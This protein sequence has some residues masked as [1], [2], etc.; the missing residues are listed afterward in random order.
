MAEI[1]FRE[2]QELCGR[3]LEEGEKLSDKTL[4][5]AQELDCKK[6]IIE[7]LSVESEFLDD[8]FEIILGI[9]ESMTDVTSAAFAYFDKVLY[10]RIY[11]GERYVFP[12]PFML[13]EDA[14]A[15]AACLN[16]ASYARRELIPF[17]ITDVPREELEFLCSV[18]PHIDAFTYEDDDDSFYVKVNNE[19][20]MLDEIPTIEI[21]GITLD[22]IRDSDKEKYA[23]LCRDRDLNK[24][25]G[26]DVDAD[27]PE[28][29]ADY[30]LD[31][32]RREINDGVAIA[33]AVREN[34]EF[35]GEATI[36]DFDFRGCASIAVRILPSQHSRG[37]GSR[38]I[39]A[40]IE[41]ARMI[42]LNE[43][44]AEVLSENEKSI[45]MTSKYMRIT[46][47]TKSKVYFA[48]PL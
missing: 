15:E 31:I 16:L 18:F 14:D 2:I 33:L 29:D 44:R 32:A 11:D 13:V 12:L 23:Q 26:Y 28:G 17:I 3:A 10:V 9:F 45:K 30:Y 37:L 35:V 4:E 22:E 8:V 25:W 6:E 19:C 34:G 46:N 21:D 43:I 27:N 5:E 20:D 40:L 24:Y 39:K 41:Y 47:Q 38:A 36:Y 7:A 48:L 1:H 42:C